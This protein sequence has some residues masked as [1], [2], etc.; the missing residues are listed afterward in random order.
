MEEKAPT[1][2]LDFK[3]VF[4]RLEKTAWTCCSERPQQSIATELKTFLALSRTAESLVM[5]LQNE[6]LLANLGS[7]ANQP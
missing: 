4:E 7:S 5:S 3:D 6:I 2:D 1:E